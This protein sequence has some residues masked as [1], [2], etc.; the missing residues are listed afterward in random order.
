[1]SGWADPRSTA[2]VAVNMSTVPTR[3][4]SSGGRKPGS[5]AVPAPVDSSAGASA[6]AFGE[7]DQR[8]DAVGG[9][10]DDVVAFSHAH[11]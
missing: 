8:E 7:G 2:G 4:L 10:D 1:M 6:F 5:G 11:Q 3:L 9:G